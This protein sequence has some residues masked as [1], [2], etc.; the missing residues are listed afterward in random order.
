MNHRTTKYLENAVFFQTIIPNE[1]LRFPDLRDDSYP[2]WFISDDSSIDF[3]CLKP[4]ELTAILEFASNNNIPYIQF[5][6][7]EHK[8]SFPISSFGQSSGNFISPFQLVLIE[9]QMRGDTITNQAP[10]SSDMHIN[11]DNLRDKLKSKPNIG[12]IHDKTM[13]NRMLDA[14]HKIDS[15]S[16]NESYQHL[17][18][19]I[20]EQ[21]IIERINTPSDKLINRP[22]NTNTLISLEKDIVTII[23]N[24]AGSGKG[25]IID[26]AFRALN[27]ATPSIKKIKK[28]DS[29]PKLSERNLNFK[30]SS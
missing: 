18:K 8:D 19:P 23:N 28:A 27:S 22:I 15:L 9:A 11:L 5:E 4:T 1:H 2:I 29:N 20:L 3:H 7:Y 13:I 24:A 6:T 21:C 10:V 26:V 14:I 17:I 30:Q 16:V 25:Q 12:N